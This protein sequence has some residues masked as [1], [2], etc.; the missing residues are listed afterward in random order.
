MKHVGAVTAKDRNNGSNEVIER[1]P[2]GYAPTRYR[3]WY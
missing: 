1:R 2:Y 3:G